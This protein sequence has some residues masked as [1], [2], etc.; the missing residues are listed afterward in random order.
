MRLGWIDFSKS[1]RSKVLSVLDL[2]SQRGT[3]DELGIAPVRDGF[4]DLFFPGTST[5]Q[6][7]AKYFLIIPYILKD[8]ELDKETNPRQLLRKLDALEKDCA[9]ILRKKNED[10]DGIIGSRSLSQGGWVKRAPSSIYWSGLRS[11]GI[12]TAPLSLTE[13]IWRMCDQKNQK[14]MLAGLGNRNDRNDDPDREQD[15]W[16]AGGL[17]RLQFWSVPTY[18]EDWKENLDLRLTEEESAYLKRQIIISHPDSMMAFILKN[19][20]DDILRCGSFENLNGLI[21]QFPD[22]IQADYRL[23]RDFA[24]YLLVLRVLYNMIVSEGEN[25]RASSLWADLNP[26]LERIAGADIEGIIQR[27]NLFRHTDLCIFLRK[28][29]GLMA[30][31]DME[32][33]KEAIRKREYYLKDARAKTAHPGEFDTNGGLIGGELLDYRFG[34]A[35]RIMNDIFESGDQHAKSE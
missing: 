18:R 27:L 26:E 20:R 24:E 28:A 1:E 14:K 5:I 29:K 6:T 19:H 10:Q 21:H 34:N 7:R 17:Y 2:L 15:D 4:A 9:E 13:Y 33:L 12:F 32:G 31:K 23:A 8:L 25:G 22:R 11:Y 35:G 16:D 30:D 3:L